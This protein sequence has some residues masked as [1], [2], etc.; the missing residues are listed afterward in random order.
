EVA[1]R[2]GLLAQNATTPGDITVQELV[3]RGRYPHQPLFTR[4]RKD[5]FVVND[6]TVAYVAGN[7]NTQLP[8]WYRVAATWGAHEGSLLLWVL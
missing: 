2:I 5:A 6:F 4:W 3:A 1:R 8:V 7:S